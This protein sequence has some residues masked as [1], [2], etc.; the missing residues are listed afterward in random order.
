MHILVCVSGL[1]RIC[2][3]PVHTFVG[4]VLDLDQ[5]DRVLV[6]VHKTAVLPTYTL[7]HRPV[8]RL[9]SAFPTMV[10]TCCGAE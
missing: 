1:G 3:G 7:G 4:H 5:F 2:S 6:L 8:A 10:V 9:S